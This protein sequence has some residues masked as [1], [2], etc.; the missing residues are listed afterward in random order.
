MADTNETTRVGLTIEQ[1][2]QIRD[3]AFW[4][5]QIEQGRRLIRDGSGL[6]RGTIPYEAQRDNLE[7][8]TAT[9]LRQIEDALT[10]LDRVGVERSKQFWQADWWPRA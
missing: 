6:I 5:T 7:V 1:V 10:V 3:R 2:H 8:E 9:A 4:Q